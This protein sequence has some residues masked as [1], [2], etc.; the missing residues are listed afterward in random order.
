MLHIRLCRFERIGYFGYEQIVAN[1]AR[2]FS[3]HLP[4][5]FGQFWLSRA[6]VQLERYLGFQQHGS[7]DV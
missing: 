7:P 5:S 3:F 1:T 4:A 6:V 2:G